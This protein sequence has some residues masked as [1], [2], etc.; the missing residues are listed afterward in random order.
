MKFNELN[1]M[2]N[3]TKKGSASIDADNFMK[4]RVRRII[5]TRGETQDGS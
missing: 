2:N 4:Q 5:Q 3:S 1:F